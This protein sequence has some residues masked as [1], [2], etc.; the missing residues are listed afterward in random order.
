M[1]SKNESNPFG[2][3]IA[4]SSIIIAILFV[5]GFSYRWSYYYNFGAQHLV[6]DLNLQSFLIAAFELIREPKNLLVSI[7]IVVLPLVL[8]NLSFSWLGKKS[9][10]SSRLTAGIR[11]LAVKIGVENPLAKDSLRAIILIY[12]VYMLSSQ[13]GYNSFKKDI[14]NSKTNRLPEVT[15]V[16]DGNKN[17][18]ASP[19]GCGSKTSEFPVV[20]GNAKHIDLIRKAFLTCSVQ[21]R[22]WRLLHRDNK[23]IY[24][25]A[26]EPPDKASGKRP[27]TLMVPQSN[28]IYI[29][30]K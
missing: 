22:T 1:N 27:L 26:S 25:F 20:I 15:L 13:I 10:N 7:P 2:A 16:F 21:G 28:N 4:A 24:I 11:M 23:A 6:F 30:T 12:S 14:V 5:A 9:Q 29:V 17:D 18:S 8:L 3:L 19:I